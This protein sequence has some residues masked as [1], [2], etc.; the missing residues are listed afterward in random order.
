VALTVGVPIALIT[1]VGPP[2]PHTVPKLSALTS[3]LDITAI[4]RILSVIVWLAWVQLVWCV[5]VE[6]KAAASHAAAS[7]KVPLAG[8]T[9]SLA[10]RRGAAG[11]LAAPP[12]APPPPAGYHPRPPAARPPGPPPGNPPPGDARHPRHAGRAHRGPG[13]AVAP[14]RAELGQDVHGQPASR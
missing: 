13:A 14:P 3:Q 8:A 12:A 10:P 5:L 1:L 2:L 11:S 4:L 6:V 9:Q 7:P